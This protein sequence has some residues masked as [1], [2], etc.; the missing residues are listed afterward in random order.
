MRLWLPIAA[1]VLVLTADAY[2]RCGP[3]DIYRDSTKDKIK[4]KGASTFEA[5]SG[6]L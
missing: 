6:M 4:I 5:P 1:V 2:G 3:N